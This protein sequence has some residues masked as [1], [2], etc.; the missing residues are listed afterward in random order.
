MPTS[1]G[2]ASPLRPDAQESMLY[3]EEAG[4]ERNGS[5]IGCGPTVCQVLYAWP[6][7]QEP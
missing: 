7:S 2:P 5:N 4:T 6:H 1:G 3:D